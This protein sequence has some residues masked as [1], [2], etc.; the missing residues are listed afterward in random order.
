[1]LGSGHCG[2]LLFI[3]LDQFKILNDSKG[4][5]VGDRLLCEVA[6]RLRAE[7]PGTDLV[8]R[9][10]GDEFVVLLQSLGADAEKAVEK[11]DRFG[12]EIGE[13]IARPF[14]LDGL[15]FHTT[16]SIGVALFQG[17]EGEVDDLLKRADLAMYEAKTAGRASL[18]FFAPV[19]Q[20]TLEDGIALTAELKDALIN[21]G[22]DLVYQPQVDAMAPAG[23]RRVLS[24]GI[25]RGAAGLRPSNF[26][27]RPSGAASQA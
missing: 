27:R 22:L 21:G 24:D 26:W 10:G 1:M 23:A 19:M 7:T 18:R 12:R 8:A 9:F 4:H 13:A 5:H 20:A 6:D 17:A 25:T 16:A 2:A 11:V 15:P 14:T 3:D